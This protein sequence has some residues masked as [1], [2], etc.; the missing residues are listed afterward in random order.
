MSGPTIYQV[1]PESDESPLVRAAELLRRGGLVAHPTETVYGLA[2]D[3]WREV[4]LERLI[5]LKGRNA[6]KGL[7][8]IASELKEARELLAPRLPRHWEAL[9]AEFWPG[10]LTLIL[11]AGMRAPEAVLGPG[12]GVAI[13]LTSDPIARRLIELAGRPLTSTSANLP[14][15]RPA[16]TAA[17]VA[18][19]F[20]EGVDLILDGGPRTA[21]LASTLVDLTRGEPVVLREGAITSDALRKIISVN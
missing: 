5:S 12:G 17:G 3:P 13:R 18:E 20:H 11:P 16:Q 19:Y 15:E 1:S 6:R 9:A 21:N 2:V 10:P 14:G 8:L 4:A 7:I